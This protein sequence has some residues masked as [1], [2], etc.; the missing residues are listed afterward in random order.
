M[1]SRAVHDCEGPAFFFVLVEHRV[2]T[3]QGSDALSHYLLERDAQALHVLRTR[4]LGNLAQRCIPFRMA[5]ASMPFLVFFL[6]PRSP[7]AIPS[8]DC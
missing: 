8:S 2:E 5:A 1:K 7:S 6:R 4:I 3:G